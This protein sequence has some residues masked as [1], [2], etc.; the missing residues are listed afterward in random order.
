VKGPDFEQVVDRQYK[1]CWTTLV[2]K[3]REYADDQDRLR[4]FKIAAGL[5]GS[6]P[7][8]A[9]GGMLAKHLV[10]IFDLINETECAPTHVW[11]EKLTDAMNYLLLLRAITV[12][13]LDTKNHQSSQ[14]STVAKIEVVSDAP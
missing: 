13:E 2:E 7:R 14:S 12:E 1:M 4:N 6:T 3:A 10:S 8:Q 11:D 5:Q 9:L